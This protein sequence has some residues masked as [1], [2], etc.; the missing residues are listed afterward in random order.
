MG[1]QSEKYGNGNLSQ[2]WKC[3]F[4]GT[5]ATTCVPCVLTPPDCATA[6]GS[7]DSAPQ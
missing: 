7:V 4:C 1:L 6:S 3:Y 5:T 2:V